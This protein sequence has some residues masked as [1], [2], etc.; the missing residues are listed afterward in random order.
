MVLVEI[1]KSLRP[2]QWTKN[3]VVFAPLIFSQNIFNFPLVLESVFAFA[4][5]CVLSGAVYI[6]NDLRDM[7]ED[8][9]DDLTKELAKLYR[10]NIATWESNIGRDKTGQVFL[11]L[12]IS[13]KKMSGGA[14]GRHSYLNYLK[15]VFS[16][17]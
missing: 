5:F 4:V 6:L 9:L 12:M 13:A 3:L 8:K 11:R 7:D 15:S 10:E 17:R 1:V 2:Y 14:L 16:E